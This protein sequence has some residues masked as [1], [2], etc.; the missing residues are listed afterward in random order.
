MANKTVKFNTKIINGNKVFLKASD[1]S[2]AL[3]YSK[4]QDFGESV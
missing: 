2:K 1:V 4:V 3:G